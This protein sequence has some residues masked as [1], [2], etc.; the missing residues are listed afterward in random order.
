MDRAH[1]L[2]LA[3]IIPVVSGKGM[4]GNGNRASEAAGGFRLVG[5]GEH[6]GG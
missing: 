1:E 4:T 5:R 3:V 6:Q 2:S